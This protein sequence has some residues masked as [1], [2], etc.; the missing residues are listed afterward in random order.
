[1]LTTK[2]RFEQHCCVLVRWHPGPSRDRDYC[3]L[4]SNAC[5]HFLQISRPMGNGPLKCPYY[6]YYYCYYLK[7]VRLP[8][9]EWLADRLLDS[10]MCCVYLFPVHL[11]LSFQF[12]KYRFPGKRCSLSSV[13]PSLMNTA[14]IQ[15]TEQSYIIL[16][17][18][19]IQFSGI[20]LFKC[21]KALIT[22]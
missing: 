13:C 22:Y 21:I 5:A 9:D 12:W 6:Y 1:M 14:P 16:Y 8:L 10:G 3:S 7:I 20:Y 15:L 17:F 4:R 18:V 11:L 19:K 2:F